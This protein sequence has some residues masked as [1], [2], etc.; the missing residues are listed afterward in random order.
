MEKICLF[1]FPTF[2]VFSV[3]SCAAASFLPL[4]YRASSTKY[5]LLMCSIIR[6]M[7]WEIILI[8][9]FYSFIAVFHLLLKCLDSFPH[10]VLRK[11]KQQE[12]ARYS[13]IWT[14]RYWKILLKVTIGTSGFCISHQKEINPSTSQKDIL[15][16]R[17]SW[18]YTSLQNKNSVLISILFSLRSCKQFFYILLFSCG[19]HMVLVQPPVLSSL[20]EYCICLSYLAIVFCSL[21]KT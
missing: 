3:L 6:E 1:K 4:S 10:L 21:P 11:M 17:R 5:L 9:H 8:S 20:L 19:F 14:L 2:H 13:H 15:R 18:S 7:E 16:S 12:S